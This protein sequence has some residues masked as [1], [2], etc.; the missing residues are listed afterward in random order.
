MLLRRPCYS[1]LI[2]LLGAV[3]TFSGCTSMQ[4]NTH[5]SNTP[6][7]Y[8]RTILSDSS[9]IAYLSAF[10]LRQ[11]ADSSAPRIAL[12]DTV[13]AP[14]L[15]FFQDT[16][17]ELRYEISR[18]DTLKFRSL[19]REF[20]YEIKMRYHNFPR[21]VDTAIRQMAFPGR[22]N[23]LVRFSIADSLSVPGYHLVVIQCDPLY[24]STYIHMR[25]SEGYSMTDRIL[26][27]FIFR[28]GALV[29]R[30][31]KHIVR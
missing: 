29:D 4:S 28:N 17:T 1:R 21:S 22:C 7:S 24:S 18:R 10:R 31:I 15:F 23:T 26:A 14:N 16:L 30:N 19:E 20:G 3:I 13:Y 2:V 11:F 27:L 8:Y 25:R 9:F 12:N 5:P 6:H